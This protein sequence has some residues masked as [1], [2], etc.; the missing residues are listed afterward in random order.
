MCVLSF[1]SPKERTKEKATFFE[2]LRAKKGAL[3]WWRTALLGLVGLVFCLWLATIGL[4]GFGLGFGS[5]G[6][7]WEVHL[8]HKKA[9]LSFRLDLS[10]RPFFVE[11]IYE[12]VESQK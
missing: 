2:S 11:G 12:I 8:R 6:Q 5:S 3:R 10:Y 1:A 9:P 4:L 7:F